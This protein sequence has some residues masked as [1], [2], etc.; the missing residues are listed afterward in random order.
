MFL[1]YCYHVLSVDKTR[2]AAYAESNP[3]D[4]NQCSW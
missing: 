3:L 4:E 2:M 1:Y